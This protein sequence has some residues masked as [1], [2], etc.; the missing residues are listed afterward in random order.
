MSV[1]LSYLTVDGMSYDFLVVLKKYILYIN[2]FKKSSLFLITATHFFFSL[3]KDGIPQGF[4][5]AFFHRFVV[6]L[7]TY[8]KDL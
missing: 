1:R 6:I 2:K 4:K 3:R 7:V 5:G 8:S